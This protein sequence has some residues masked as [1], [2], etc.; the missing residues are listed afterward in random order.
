TGNIRKGLLIDAIED[1]TYT[2]LHSYDYS[3][4]KSLNLVINP[5]GGGNVGIGTSKPQN[6]LEIQAEL[7]TDNTGKS[8]LRFSNLNSNY[9]PVNNP[10]NGVLSV[11]QNGNVVYVKNKVYRKCNDTSDKNADLINDVD[12]PLNNNTFIFKDG[13]L[14]N[15]IRENRV[16]IGEFNNCSVN[17]KL[18]VKRDGET[19][20][21]GEG[22]NNTINPNVNY[23][24]D[25]NVSNSTTSYGMFASTT[26]STQAYGVYSDAR[27][28]GNSS[29][30]SFSYRSEER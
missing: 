17:A 16:G 1:G 28:N 18:H 27:V 2:R 20:L 3:Q 23:G 12:L 11:D 6:K 10:G 14:K 13:D 25:L 8:G 21:S 29:N 9:L 4:G 19:F 26:G 5:F 24:V 30:N 15:S 22:V 7:N